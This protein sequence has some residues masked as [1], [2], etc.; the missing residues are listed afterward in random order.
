MAEVAEIHPNTPPTSPDLPLAQGI[1]E[2]RAKLF[3]VAEEPKDAMDKLRGFGPN[4]VYFL[5]IPKRFQPD[6]VNIVYKQGEIK[7]RGHLGMHYVHPD[8]ATDSEKTYR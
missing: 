6:E 1:E 3:S 2:N 4:G 7:F 8:F 5:D